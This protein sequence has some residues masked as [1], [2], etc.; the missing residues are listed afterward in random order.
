MSV[1]SDYTDLRLHVTDHLKRNDLDADMERFVRLCEAHA[2]RAIRHSDMIVDAVLTLTDGVAALPANFLEMDY[3]GDDA[4]CRYKGVEQSLL[5]EY[6]NRLGVYYISGSNLYASQ[7][8]ATLNARY[9]AS[10][11][12]LATSASTTNWLLQKHPNAYFYGVLKEAYEFLEN[13]DRAMW[14][15]SKF[16]EALRQVKIDGDRKRLGDGVVRFARIP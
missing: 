1:F 8:A 10:L 11:T 12:S 2:N 3:L 6:P 15:T 13:D 5:R 16:D 9:Y 7:F 14:A 4:G